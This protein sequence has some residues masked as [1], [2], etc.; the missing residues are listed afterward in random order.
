MMDII[1]FKENDLLTMKK[2]HPCSPSAYDF[3][4]TRLGSEVRIKCVCCSREMSMQRERLEKSIRFIN[5]Q[6]PIKNPPV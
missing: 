1:R 4:V 3:R 5:G 6:K 2:N